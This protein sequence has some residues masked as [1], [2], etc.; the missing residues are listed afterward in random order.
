MPDSFVEWNNLDSS[1]LLGYRFPGP[2]VQYSC[3]VCAG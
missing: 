1:R 2:G 3:R